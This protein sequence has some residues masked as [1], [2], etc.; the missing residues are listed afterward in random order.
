MSAKCRSGI[1]GIES[2]RWK[3]EASDWDDLT[4]DVLGCATCQD[5]AAQQFVYRC[6]WQSSPNC[7][8]KAIAADAC[9]ECRKDET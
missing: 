7:T 2:H 4:E 1:D 5:C 3:I 6:E 8:G 9:L